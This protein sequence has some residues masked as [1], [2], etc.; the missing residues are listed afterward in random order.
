MYSHPCFDSTLHQN[1]KIIKLRSHNVTCRT[2]NA[3][4]CQDILIC[5]LLQLPSTLLIIKHFIP[6]AFSSPVGI[7]PASKDNY[8]IQLLSLYRILWLLVDLAFNQSNGNKMASINRFIAIVNK[9]FLLIP[10]FFCF[11]Y[12]SVRDTQAVLK[13]GC[14]IVDIFEKNKTDWNLHWKFN[15][16]A[17]DQNTTNTNN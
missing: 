15:I 4:I 9:I 6:P 11:G 5:Y 17:T 10:N 2:W 14:V 3:C 8:C 13:M 16:A 7:S 12:Y 1:G